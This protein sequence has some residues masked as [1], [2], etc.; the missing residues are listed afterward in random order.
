MARIGILTFHNTPNFGATLQCYALFRRLE[1]EGAEV[2]VI[3]YMPLHTIGM[4]ARSQ[5]LGSRRSLKNFGKIRR[6]YTF[7]RDRLKV[8]GPPIF[9]RKGL[10]ALADRYDVVFTGSDE[11]WKVDHMRKL[12]PS[13]YF[14][15]L[16]PARTRL[17]GYAASA[18]T[19]TDLRD[20][21]DVTGP[22][23]RRFS[24]LGVR[25]PHTAESVRD[26][27]G[28]EP[29]QVLDPTLIWPFAAAEDLPPLHPRPYVGVY[30]WVSP[31][32]MASIRRLASANRLDVVCFGCHDAA[33][34]ANYVAIGPHEWLR[35]V[36]HA[37]LVV[38]NFFHGVAFALIFRRRLF[39]YVD[40]KKR[41]KLRHLLD[42][43]GLAD[44]L[45]ADDRALAGMT[46][47][48][49]E[50]DHDAA[51]ARLA[52]LREASL[53][54]LRGELAGGGPSSSA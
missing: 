39:A 20:H 13:F 33:A 48:G 38:T 27:T 3:N 26:L 43:V 46:L 15:F 40:E 51:E 30:S 44:R 16:D 23:L 8:S 6:F 50:I 28:R 2:E 24:G 14:D 53:A 4:Y 11:V 45:H 18:S 31:E 9:S 21:A 1:H 17:S 10:R 52:P 12:D 54:Y 42:L 5:F 35:L 32:A 22:L 29:V 36:K 47:E 49:C 41:M 19:V 37:E 25:D 7:V 34:D